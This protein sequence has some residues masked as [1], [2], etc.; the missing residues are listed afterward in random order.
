[1]RY[2]G[3]SSNSLAE[4]I[5]DYRKK[6]VKILNPITKKPFKKEWLPSIL[7]LSLSFILSIV[8]SLFYGVTIYTYLLIHSFFV[9]I[10]GV[11][12][13]FP[14]ISQ[15]SHL[16]QQFLLNDIFTTKKLVIVK[17]LKSKIYKLP[18]TFKNIKL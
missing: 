12:F 13:L 18:Y 7:Y 11:T 2:F 10:W 14:Q 17:N 8:Y 1:M 4:I 6:S 9:M 5:I 16:F 3:G 15:Y